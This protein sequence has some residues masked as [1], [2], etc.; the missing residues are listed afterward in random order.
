MK[1]KEKSQKQKI[2]CKFVL[3]QLEQQQNKGRKKGR[4]LQTHTQKKQSKRA[5]FMRGR[6][7]FSWAIHNLI[8]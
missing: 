6:I 7:R 5:Y 3:T 2:L 1:K 8:T 4:K